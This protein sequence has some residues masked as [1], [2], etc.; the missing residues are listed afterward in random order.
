MCTLQPDVGRQEKGTDRDPET[1]P[2]LRALMA[3][4][5]DGGEGGVQRHHWVRNQLFSDRHLR[6]RKESGS[7]QRS[8][9]AYLVELL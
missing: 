2:L 9:K 1:N 6:N 5:A 4:T 8:Q 7:R 3:D